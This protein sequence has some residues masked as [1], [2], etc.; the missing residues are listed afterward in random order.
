[1]N[2][3]EISQL[4]QDAKDASIKVISEEEV[5]PTDLES[6]Y[7]V[8][9]INQNKLW[10]NLSS[11]MESIKNRL[12][13]SIES[14]ADI[15]ADYMYSTLLNGEDIS[16]IFIND[17]LTGWDRIETLLNNPNSL[18]WDDLK[19][20]D[21]AAIKALNNKISIK[22]EED[23]EAMEQ[24]Q[25][26]TLE[27]EELEKISTKLDTISYIDDETKDAVKAIVSWA[28]FG[29]IAPELE[30]FTNNFSESIKKAINE[31]DITFNVKKEKDSFMELVRT[32][33]STSI[34]RGSAAEKY[35]EECKKKFET[36]FDDSLTALVKKAADNLIVKDL[37]DCETLWEITDYKKNNPTYK[38]IVNDWCDQFFDSIREG[39]VRDY[40][41]SIIEW[42]KVS[43][44][45]RPPKVK[46]FTDSVGNKYAKFKDEV[47]PVAHNEKET[48]SWKMV[49]KILPN[50]N[51]MITFV[52]LKSDTSIEPNDEK[53]LRIDYPYEVSRQ[54]WNQI[55]KENKT[56]KKKLN[57]IEWIKAEIEKEQNDEKKKE[58]IKK[59]KDLIVALP[60]FAR[61]QDK[62]SIFDRW[63]GD[64]IEDK[65]PDFDS[66]RTK[67]TPDIMENLREMTE[68]AN[69]MLK[70]QHDILII[71]WEAWVWKNVIIDIFAHFTN[72]PVFV[73]SCWKRTDVQDLT[74]L[75]ILDEN[76]SKKLNSKVVEAIHTPNAILVFDEI[77]TLDPGIQK[78][79]NG[80]F[81]GR[82]SLV[83]DDAWDKEKSEKAEK[84]VLFFGT[85]NP[86]GYSGTQPL[87]Q[88]VRTRGHFIYHDYDWLLHENPS[89]WNLD[90]SYSDALK[91][92]G[93]VK[94]FWKLASWNGFT[95][96]DIELY[97]EAVLDQVHGNRLTP[98]KKKILK[99]FKP[100][101]DSDFIW[102]WN[103]LF[104]GGSKEEVRNKFGDTFIS[105]MQDLYTM[106]LYANYIRMRYKATKETR[107]DSDL[108]W[109]EDTNELFDDISFSPRLAIQALE[110]LHNWW[111]TAKEAVIETFVGQLTDVN[112]RPKVIEFFDTL[113]ENNIKRVLTNSTIQKHLFKKHNNE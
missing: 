95:Q 108:P 82:K 11:G 48:H 25:F 113:S 59:L 8:V 62:L 72:R 91:V 70:S 64:Y 85:M 18:L 92:Y 14:A 17:I 99:N 34:T 81:D 96:N 97:E 66:D 63:I 90:I 100:I 60:H 112:N 49:P 84:S 28:L 40:I 79:L 94:Y 56:Y 45:S 30:K 16:K 10:E 88:D 5:T 93:N 89:N 9:N 101:S 12:V 47:I 73:F 68:C 102:A 44:K 42:A 74:Y 75:W 103:N 110:Q 52:D 104:N 20:S 65:I 78:R 98:E 31:V 27:T 106:M 71:E 58:L 29:K 23:L 46:T 2:N 19:L 4:L 22:V 67:I 3:S 107:E 6:I 86:Q 76:G 21:D 35:M 77:N 111:L 109:D 39:E 53:R 33:E 32:I 36:L 50:G 80:L 55:Q 26:D 13:E 24:S 51:V 83:V 1:M 38:H 69:T 87:A 61:V 105:W 15:V 41:N 37:D 7:K 54:E 57:E 43:I